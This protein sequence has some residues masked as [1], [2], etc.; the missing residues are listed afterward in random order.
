[1]MVFS[2]ALCWW[3]GMKY[4]LREFMKS[5]VMVF[6]SGLSDWVFPTQSLLH[7]QTHAGLFM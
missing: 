5:F 2:T 4:V 3:C 1:M 7:T 6:V